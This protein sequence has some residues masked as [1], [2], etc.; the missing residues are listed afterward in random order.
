LAVPESLR[1]QRDL[2]ILPGKPIPPVTGLF[3]YHQATVIIVTIFYT[4]IFVF[5][6]RRRGWLAAS[7]VAFGIVFGLLQ[8]VLTAFGLFWASLPLEST[9]MPNN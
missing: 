9:G 4:M 7:L 3:L 5:L 1:I 2:D 8:I 6:A